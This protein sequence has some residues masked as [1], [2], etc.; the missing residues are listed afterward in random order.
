MLRLESFEIG[1]HAA[2]LRGENDTPVRAAERLAEQG[3]RALLDRKLPDARRAL[4]FAYGIN[5][6]AGNLYER[7]VVSDL[8]GRLYAG[9]GQPHLAV[10]FWIEC[11]QEK[12]AV[13]AAEDVPAAVLVEQLMLNRSVGSGPLATRCSQPPGHT[14][15]ESLVADLI[16]PLLVA[17][18]ARPNGAFGPQPSVRARAALAAIAPGVPDARLDEVRKLLAE[19]LGNFPNGH[20]ASR[21]LVRLTIFDRSDETE[22]LAEAVLGHE[23][24]NNSALLVHWLGG[25][26]SRYSALTERFCAAALNGDRDALEALLVA[27]LIEGDEELIA[28]TERVESFLQRPPFIEESSEG[29]TAVRGVTLGTFARVGIEGRYCSEAVRDQLVERLLEIVAHDGLPQMNLFQRR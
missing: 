29:G 13:K 18:R 11:G 12:Q 26:L 16:E 19:E 2:Q 27:E 25:R 7:M 9:A 8:L 5:R 22:R 3:M 24:L 4:W 14:V 28:V 1:R 17:A 20:E 21:A 10:R 6:V 15:D 23:L